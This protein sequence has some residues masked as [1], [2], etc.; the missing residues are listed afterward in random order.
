MLDTCREIAENVASVDNGWLR[1]GLLIIETLDSLLWLGPRKGN[2]F[3]G[4][5]MPAFL[6]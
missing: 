6:T 4:L 1:C 2:C 3:A 5:S